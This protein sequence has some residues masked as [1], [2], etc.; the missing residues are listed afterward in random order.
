M[1]LR[2]VVQCNACKFILK[3]YLLNLILINELCMKQTDILNT[4]FTIC[5]HPFA[6]LF[7]AFY[8]SVSSSSSLRFPYHV[9]PPLNISDSNKNM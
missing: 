2:T 1:V 6:Y 3:H 4:F 9:C 8:S 7:R 5:F